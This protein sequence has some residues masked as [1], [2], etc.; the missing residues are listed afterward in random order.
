MALEL[1]DVAKAQ[2][3]AV[4]KELSVIGFD[5]NP[6]T[7]TSSIELSTVSQPLVEMGRLGVENLHQITRG[8]AK[9]PVKFML[10]TTFVKRRSCSS[11]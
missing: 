1:L 11:V 2:K 10:A 5:D 7:K 4:P 6:L 9:L 3:V 8:K